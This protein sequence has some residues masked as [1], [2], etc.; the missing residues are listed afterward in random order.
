MEDGIAMPN[1]PEGTFRLSLKSWL[2]ALIQSEVQ[3]N[4]PRGTVP[5][6]QSASS[7]SLILLHAC[8]AYSQFF[9]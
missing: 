9:P 7:V 2:E 5:H 6:Q 1:K 3:N 8:D 4:P